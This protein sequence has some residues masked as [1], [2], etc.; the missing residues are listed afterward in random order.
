L[1]RGVATLDQVALRLDAFRIVHAG[2]L[3]GTALCIITTLQLLLRG[4]LAL[5]LGML[6]TLD[7]LAR[8]LLAIH[9]LHAVAW[10]G[11]AAG[12]IRLLLAVVALAAVFLRVGGGGHAQGQG[13]AQGN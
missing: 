3:A 8:L 12:F 4:L 10:L 7:I 5:A 11:L 13:G 9:G 1:L 6:G 2:L